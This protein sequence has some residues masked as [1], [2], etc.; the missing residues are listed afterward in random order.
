MTDSN[1]A[2]KLPI[3]IVNTVIDKIASFTKEME[4]LRAQIPDKTATTD[5]IDALTLKMEKT[6]STIK[7]VFV[8]AMIVV[9]LS[10]LGAQLLKWN[11]TKDAVPDATNEIVEQV[12]RQIGTELDNTLE[13]FKEEIRQERKG[14][15]EQILEKM[16][17]LHKDDNK[18]EGQGDKKESGYSWE[19]KN[20]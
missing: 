17:E 8:L 14:D 6:L 7:T 19:N 16:E 9:G 5:K 3:G 11:E 20:F 4:I 15:L 13:K 1:G 10:F 18:P 2:D 12:N